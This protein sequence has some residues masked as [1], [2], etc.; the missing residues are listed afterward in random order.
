MKIISKALNAKK[1]YPTI[2]FSNQTAYVNKQC[3]SES[4]QLTSDIM[5]VCEKQNIG[6]RSIPLGPGHLVTMDIG[7]AFDSIE[8]I[9]SVGLN[10][11]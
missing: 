7:K 3:I 4:G 11:C 5:E 6:G 9:L 2:I 1:T 10:Y 8:V